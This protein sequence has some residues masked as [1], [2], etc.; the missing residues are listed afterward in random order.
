MDFTDV[1]LF[2]CTYIAATK[3]GRPTSSAPHRDVRP[4][5]RGVPCGKSAAIDEMREKSVSL[6][7]Y[8]YFLDARTVIRRG[9][10]LFPRTSH[11]ATDF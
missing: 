6:F 10:S 5:A 7:V 3:L 1:V 4:T 2:P 11:G 8:L 9:G